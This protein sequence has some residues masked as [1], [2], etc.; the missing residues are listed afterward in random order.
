MIKL[1]SVAD[2]I[3]LTNLIFGFFAIIFLIS[4]FITN[5]DLK[6]RISF[7]FILLALLADGLDGI[8][9]RKTKNSDIGEY[10]ESIAD[11]TSLIIAPSIFIY[12]V[13]HDFLTTNEY[14]QIYLLIAFILF[15]SLGA[16]RL[17]S[18]HVMK[19]KEFYLGLPASVATIILLVFSYLEI[20][21]ILIFTVILILSI[22]MIS[23]IRFPK[24][25]LKINA[26]ASILIILSIIIGKEFYGFA[27]ILL[28]IAIFLYSIVGPIYKRF[29]LKKIDGNI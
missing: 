29:S 8:V 12:F 9:A 15:L 25:D 13:Y 2:L 18:F 5:E 17:A 28:I 19:K 26:I 4:D 1:V 14:Y 27:P 23:N 16:I 10:L 7:S 11:M 21:F 20:S 22:A 3:S 24:P 6:L